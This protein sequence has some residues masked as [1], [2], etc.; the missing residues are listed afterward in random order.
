MM[1]WRW[2]RGEMNEVVVMCGRG[3]MM[4]FSEEALTWERKWNGLNEWYVS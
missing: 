4:M 2:M 3:G 1:R